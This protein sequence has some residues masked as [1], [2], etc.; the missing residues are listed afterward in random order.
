MALQH[1]PFQEMIVKKWLGE[2]NAENLRWYARL[3]S[4]DKKIIRKPEL[5]SLIAAHLNG[6]HLREIWSRLDDIQQAA[7]AEPSIRKT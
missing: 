2:E 7:V 4:A 3:L 1:K 6:V 5:I